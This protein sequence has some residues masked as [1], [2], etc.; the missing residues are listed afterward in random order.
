MRIGRATICVCME[1]GGET[2]FYF[3]NF[4][5]VSKFLNSF[6][7]HS[8]QL[9]FCI[10][11]LLFLFFFVYAREKNILACFGRSMLDEYKHNITIELFYL[12]L[13]CFYGDRIWN[14]YISLPSSISTLLRFYIYYTISFLI[15]K[16]IIYEEEGGDTQTSRFNTDTEIS[17]VWL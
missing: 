16:S 13:F 12:F 15:K 5:F 6:W 10:V 7:F 9:D 17:E 2:D 11:V 3:L 4:N 14:Q 1:K 8:I